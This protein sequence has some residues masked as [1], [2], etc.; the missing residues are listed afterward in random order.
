MQTRLFLSALAIVS[1]VPFAAAQA[2]DSHGAPAPRAEAASAAP[3]ARP[4]RDPQAYFTD[5]ELFTQDGRK[6]RFY[7][8][9][10]KG[11]LVV[12]N[13]IFTHCEDACPLITA[14]MNAVRLKLGPAF[15]RDVHFVSISSDPVRDTPQALKKWAAKQSVDVPGWTFLTGKKA[16]VDH[17]LQ[18]LGQWSQNIESH[19]T[20]LIA[21]NFATDRGRKMLPNLPPEALAAQITML[22]GSGSLVPLPALVPSN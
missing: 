5:R 18:K 15:E 7:S 13:T 22:S 14:Q 1:A 9:V 12:I 19:S 6:V 16:D 10:L 21:W 2:H 3:L 8:D 4:K 20:Q 17:I 11:R